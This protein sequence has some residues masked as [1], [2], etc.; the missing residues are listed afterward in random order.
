MTREKEGFVH[1]K[2]GQN[3]ENAPYLAL[4]RVPQAPVS[5]GHTVQGAG[6]ARRA[7]RLTPEVNSGYLCPAAR[8]PEGWPGAPE[9]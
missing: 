6:L 1:A 5:A 2:A 8:P 3:A 7:W 9:R 4:A